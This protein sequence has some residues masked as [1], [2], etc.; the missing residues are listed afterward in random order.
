M[1]TLTYP[2]ISL[3]LPHAEPMILLDSVI[4]VT[5]DSIG[6]KVIIQPDSLFYETTSEYEG[7]GAWV[8]IEYMA[9]TM[10]AYAGYNA[11]KN[12]G[13]V[14]IGFL[15]GTRQYQCHK[16]FFAAG[17]ELHIS[18]KSIMQADNGISAFECTI[19]ENNQIIATAIINAYLPEDVII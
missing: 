14:K 18:A 17:T 12:G 6:T 5:E 16:A 10:G 13:A 8:G 7:V 1:T 19:H 2:D 9:Q 15:L 11:L 4:F 3:L